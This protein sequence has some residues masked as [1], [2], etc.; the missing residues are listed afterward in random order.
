MQGPG[1]LSVQGMSICTCARLHR[2]RLRN[3][4]RLFFG[5]VVSGRSRKAQPL[6]LRSTCMVALKGKRPL[7][8]LLRGWHGWFGKATFGTTRFALALLA[9]LLTSLVGHSHQW[10]WCRGEGSSL[11]SCSLVRSS[12]ALSS[13]S[14]ATTRATNEGQGSTQ[15]AAFAAHGCGC[16]TVFALAFSCMVVVALA[17]SLGQRG[18]VVWWSKA[19]STC[20]CLEI[21]AWVV[22]HL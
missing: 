4:R 1:P 11:L 17:L 7:L 16:A 21:A 18:N 9:S 13:L 3:S 15:R 2:T 22:W 20:C 5:R 10:C 14:R 6:L 19:L 8:A 12:G